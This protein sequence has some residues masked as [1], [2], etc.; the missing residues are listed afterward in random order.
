MNSAGD[1]GL[2]SLDGW[3]AHIAAVTA[4]VDPRAGG[5]IERSIGSLL[6]VVRE[7]L[8]LEVVFVGEFVDGNRVFRHIATRTDDAVIKPGEFHPTAETICQRIVD[9]RLPSVMHDVASVRE[10]YGLPAYYGLIGGH[11]GVPVR[12]ADG[13]LYGILCGFSFTAAPH[14]QERDVKRMEMAAH[15]TARLIAQ[16]EGRD[17]EPDAAAH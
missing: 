5:M 9:G 7:Q 4:R 14:L 13:T 8:Q 11:I 17:I 2:D 10:R 16:A 12:L 3:A 6:G 1:T 15:A